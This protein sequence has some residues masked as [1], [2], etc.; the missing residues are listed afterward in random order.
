M[1]LLLWTILM[2]PFAQAEQGPY[3]WGVG[4][5]LNTIVFP[6]HPVNF[7]K[8]ADD[9]GF[10]KTGFDMGFGVHAVMYM[11]PTQR[12]GSHL[13]YSAGAE[14]YSSPNITFEYDFIGSSANNVSVLAGL[15]GGFGAQRWK[16]ENEDKFKMSTFI[17]RAQGSVN[18]KTKRNCYEMGLF[19][20]FYFPAGSSI[21][22]ADGKDIDDIN[23]VIYPTVGLEFTGYF[24]DF[25]PPKKGRKGRRKKRGG[26]R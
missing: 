6:P 9:L 14:G 8:Q 4:P 18:F 1:L 25:T 20:N 13:W 21:E 22:K 23:F 7:P 10:K 2:T 24:G 15:G 26:R 5:T 11:R 12:F 17:L 16:N 3:M 19:A